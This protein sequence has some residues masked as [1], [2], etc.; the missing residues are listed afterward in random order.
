[1]L[2]LLFLKSTGILKAKMVTL[3]YQAYMY[4]DVISVCV[5]IHTYDIDLY[6]IYT[7]ICI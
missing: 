4:R 5:Y 2:L 1:M 7:N 3:C 6:I